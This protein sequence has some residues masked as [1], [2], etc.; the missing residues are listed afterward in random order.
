MPE[1]LDL[2]VDRGVLLDEGVCL[3]DVCLGLV[4]V[5]VADEVLDRIVG[6]QLTEFVRKL[7]RECLV[8]GEHERRALHRLDQPGGGRVPQALDLVVDRAVL[9]DVGVGLGD[10]G[11]GLVVVLSLIHI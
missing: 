9:L 10:V 11:L 6:H 8:V 5:V 1:S 4:V 3:R 2:C 7:R